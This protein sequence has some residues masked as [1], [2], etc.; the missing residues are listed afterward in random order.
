MVNLVAKLHEERLKLKIL[1]ESFFEKKYFE[2]LKTK[3]EIFRKTKKIFNH[4]LY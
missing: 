3:T 1:G 2:G 4:F